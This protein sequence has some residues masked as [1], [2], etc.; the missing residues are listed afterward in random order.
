MKPMRRAASL[1]V[2]ISL[3][4]GCLVNIQAPT[5]TPR[6]TPIPSP[7]PSPRPSPTV[8]PTATP[9]LEAVPRFSA[10]A[11]VAV[12]AP[13]LRVRARPGTDQRVITSLGLG[14]KLLVALG[15]VWV[16]DT[17]WYLIRDADRADPSFATGWAAAG[18]SN[19]PFLEAATFRVRRNPYLAGFAGEADGEFGPITL[20]DAN[21]SITWLAAPPTPAGCSFFVDLAPTDDESVRAIT[22][23]IG[24]VPAP[25]RKF[26]DFFADH[27]ELVGTEITVSV[28]SDC[29]WALTFVKERAAP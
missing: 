27:K 2:L 6:P 23:T 24:G 17:G 13:G 14:A 7:T 11:R 19:D 29:S 25:G 4:S 5:R 26:Q 21:V 8:R 28:R 16:G 18:E 10:G 22:A 3:L 12:S 20:P 1:L 15:P 9:G